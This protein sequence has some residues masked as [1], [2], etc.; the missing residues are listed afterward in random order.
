MAEAAEDTTETAQSSKTI[1]VIQGS[2]ID[3][4]LIWIYFESDGYEGG[5]IESITY[6]DEG[7]A[8]ILFQK[9]EG[10]K[11]FIKFWKTV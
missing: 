1:Y 10:N 4:G 5:A 2:N 7:G 3:E 8:Q 9:S 6:D 11:S